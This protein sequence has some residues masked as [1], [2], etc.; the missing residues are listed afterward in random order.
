VFFLQLRSRVFL[1]KAARLEGEDMP[2][3]ISI[4][5]KR[6]CEKEFK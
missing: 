5:Q 3:A 1:A 4:F 2:D 6:Y